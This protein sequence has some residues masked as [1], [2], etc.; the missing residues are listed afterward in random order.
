[1]LGTREDTL[2]YMRAYTERLR[3]VESELPAIHARAR[4]DAR[5][6]AQALRD[7]VLDAR[8]GEA[9][10]A[11]W[12]ALCAG[13]SPDELARVLVG[14][15]AHRLYRFDTEVDASPDVAETWLWAT[16]RFTF[17]SA[18]RNALRRHASADALRF[19]FQALAFIHS[20]R[21]MDAPSERR[22]EVEPAA[23]EVAAIVDAVAR[24]DVEPALAGVRGAV[25]SG[26]A[27]EPL[28]DALLELCLCDPLVRPIFVAHALKTTTA[29]FEEYDALAESP[30][31][32]LALLSAVRFLASPMR[33]R[34]VH[35]SVATSIRWVA[36]GV[37]PRKLTQ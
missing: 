3:A 11:L 4:A 30:D 8:P 35:A 28:R 17:A 27:L 32:E 5:C 18:V 14:A 19:L 1:V 37:V 10:D 13:V 34:R 20:G 24:K 36:E 23:L 26:A 22:L 9:F 25:R 7:A 31:R 2:P 21:G 33:E 15:A 6:D 29:A 12:G 16:H